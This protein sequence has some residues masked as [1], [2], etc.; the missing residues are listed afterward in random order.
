MTKEEKKKYMQDLA[1]AVYAAHTALERIERVAKEVGL[2]CANKQHMWFVGSRDKT[3]QVLVNG[4]L[5]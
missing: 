2:N 1:V 3:V 4:E 5:R